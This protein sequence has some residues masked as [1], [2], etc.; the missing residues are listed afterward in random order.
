MKIPV[1]NTFYKNIIKILHTGDTNSL[2]S[3][4]IKLLWHLLGTGVYDPGLQMSKPVKFP[5]RSCQ[6]PSNRDDKNRK[7][8]YLSFWGSSSNLWTPVMKR[9]SQ[10]CSEYIGWGSLVY[11]DDILSCNPGRALYFFFFFFSL[12]NKTSCYS[13]A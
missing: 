12:I 5:G 1:V 10:L 9:G 11:C 4:T 7:V 6:T 2:L 13:T 3:I 8:K